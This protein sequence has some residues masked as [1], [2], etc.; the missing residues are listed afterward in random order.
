MTDIELYYLKKDYLKLFDYYL[1]T[2]DAIVDMRYLLFAMFETGQ[3]DFFLQIYQRHFYRNYTN[4][5]NVDMSRVNTYLGL[6]MYSN[7]NYDGARQQLNRAITIHGE[8]SDS[9]KEWLVA[10]QLETFSPVTIDRLN[11]HFDC[12]LTNMQKTDFINKY[13]EAFSRIETL[14]PWKGKKNIDVFVFSGWI[15]N[16]GNRLSYANNHLANIYV[17]VDDDA[18]HELAHLLC[19]ST[20]KINSIFMD[21]G[22]A[23]YCDGLNRGYA[24]FNVP[25]VPTF[26]EL[27][28]SFRTYNSDFAYIYSRIFISCLFEVYNGMI[29]KTKIFFEATTPNEIMD[30]EP[31]MLDIIINHV[32]E[33]LQ[34]LKI[35]NAKGQYVYVKRQDLYDIFRT[36][37]KSE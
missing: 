21:E 1:T 37:T 14:F 10:L 33:L 35:S 12:T 36:D 34:R 32:D 22:L 16:I 8:F 6:I 17:N 20:L 27:F 3:W 26:S 29:E 28:L 13:R 18:G 5:S 24:I 4:Y 23:E 30:K 7:G 19:K 11:I 2:T 15:D 31:M 25:K 9:A